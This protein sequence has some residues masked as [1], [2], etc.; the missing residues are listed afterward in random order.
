MH[1]IRSEQHLEEGSGFS[2][3]R[4]FEQTRENV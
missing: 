4:E 1:V 3:T 2:A